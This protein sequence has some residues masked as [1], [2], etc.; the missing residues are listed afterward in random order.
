MDKKI[1]EKLVRPCVMPLQPYNPG[2]VPE[3]RVRIMANENNLG[4]SDSALRA[5]TR[6]ILSANRYPDITCA[7]LREKIAEKNGLKP[8]QIICGNGLDGVFTMIGRAFLNPGDEVICGDFTFS[9]YKSIADIMDAKAVEVPVTEEFAL[10]IDGFIA[11]VTPKTKLICLCNPNNPTG[12]FAASSEVRRLIE[13]APQDVLVIADEAYMEFTPD[14]DSVLPMLA[15]YPNLM[16]CR[17]FSKLYGLAGLRVGWAA[18]DP[19]IIAQLYKVRE[20]YCLSAVAQ[21]AALSVLDDDEYAADT[22]TLV[23]AERVRFAD[24]FDAHG[25]KYYPTAANFCLVSFGNR[26]EGIFDKLF[27]DGI[28]TRLM[29]Y[30]GEKYIR[31]SIGEMEENIFVLEELEKIIASR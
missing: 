20:P 14:T 5:M 26:T 4:V 22:K 9:A 18:A 11:A 24:F 15:E 30:K 13:A 1:L 31:F 27:A 19:D 7:E 12:S 28:L 3:T 23:A 29:S 25:I 17:T 10:D 16:V 2:K 8:E 21:A 6:A